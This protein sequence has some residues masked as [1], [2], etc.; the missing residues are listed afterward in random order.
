MV[1]A[2]NEER[3]APTPRSHRVLYALMG[4]CVV[5]IIVFAWLL[6]SGSREYSRG[7][8]AYEHIRSAVSLPMSLPGPTSGRKD[9]AAEEGDVVVPQAAPSSGIDFRVARELNGDIVGW[10]VGG[11][12]IDYPIVR[13]TDNDYYLTHLVNHERNKV[14]SIFMD[15]R[16]QGD[17]FDRA[18]VVYGHNM[19]DGSM[20]ASLMRYKSQDY[21]DQFPTMRLYTPKGDYIIKL[22]AGKVVDGNEDLACYVSAGTGDFYD[23]LDALRKVSTFHSNTVVEADDRILILCTCS[24][25]TA[26]ARFAVFGKLTPV[27]D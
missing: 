22:F 8:V 19:K 7:G 20:F 3:G 24:H 1:S 10:I 14:G 5:G 18:T 9:L 15:Y 16:N 21:F 27:S 11:E 13:G 25:E 4:L 23:Q 6:I 17:F 12:I 26:N 2:H